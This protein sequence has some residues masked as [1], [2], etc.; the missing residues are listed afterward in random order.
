M[1]SDSVVRMAVPRDA[2]GMMELAK[3][4]H[5]ESG[6]SPLDEEK[7]EDL[8]DTIFRGDGAMAG[9][10]GP[11]GAPEAMIALQI[12]LF[13]YS[14]RPHLEELFACVR[15]E[16][17]NSDHAAALL[18][19]AKQCAERANVSLLIGVISNVRMG[20]KVKMYSRLL[21]TPAGAFFVFNNPTFDRQCD[22]KFWRQVYK[23]RRGGRGR[24]KTSS[25]LRA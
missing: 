10:I 17:R 19:Y 22:P 12:G 24:N 7:L 18:R 20:A 23:T 14:T 25:E 11:V 1:T 8:F 6:V 4:A 2:A 3:F 15:P 5:A 21:G 13:W 16:Y 9:V